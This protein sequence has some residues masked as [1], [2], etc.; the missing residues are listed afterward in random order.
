MDRNQFDVK[1]AIKPK[2]PVNFEGRVVTKREAGPARD[3]N[4]SSNAKGVV[5]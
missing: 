4:V 5:A 3:R 1:D 2:T